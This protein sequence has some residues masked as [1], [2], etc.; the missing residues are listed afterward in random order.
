[1]QKLVVLFGQQLM[2]VA[3]AVALAVGAAKR[4]SAQGYQDALGPGAESRALGGAVTAGGEGA[5]ATFTNPAGLGRV[6]R[7]ELYLAMGLSGTHRES[8]LVPGDDPV[9][10]E[11]EATPLPAL[12]FGLPLVSWLVL[13]GHLAPTGFQ[14]GAYVGE[15]E[16]AGM[17]TA[18][19]LRMFE[20]GP[21]VAIL[22]PDDLVSGELTFGFG[23][24]ATFGTL[25]RVEGPSSGPADLRLDLAGGDGSGIRLGAQYSPV[26]ELRIGVAWQNQISAT[27]GAAEGEVDGAAIDR[28]QTVWTLPHRLSVGVRG[29]LDRYSLALE[30]RFSDYAASGITYRDDAGQGSWEAVETGPLQGLHSVHAGAEVRF[31]RAEFEYP[32]R[33]GYTFESTLGSPAA[34]SPFDAPPGPL[35]TLALGG[36]IH[37]RRWGTNCALAGRIGGGAGEELY[38]WSLSADFLVRFG[39]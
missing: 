28:P 4:A 2:T 20:L 12:A 23:Y 16:F 37:K 11:L 36:G 5:S 25:S 18:R 1:M 17:R 21:D 33:F 3:L 32:L 8:E 24:R 14:G 35:H 38:E 30:Y 19:T 10:S 27:L 15:D 26:P 6:E 9:A 7:P 39:D 34:L 22:V 29:E 13:G 31:S